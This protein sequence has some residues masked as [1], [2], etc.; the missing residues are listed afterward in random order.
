MLPGNA[1]LT[2]QSRPSVGWNTA[3]GLE[4][5]MAAPF[6]RPLTAELAADWRFRFWE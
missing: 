5:P 6:E 4:V 1:T 3:D 2:V